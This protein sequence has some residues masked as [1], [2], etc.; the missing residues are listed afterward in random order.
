MRDYALHQ[1]DVRFR[2][3]ASQ[4]RHASQALD[5]DTIHDLRVSI[6]RLNSC[7]RIFAQF[8]PEKAAKKVRRHLH[9]LM[10]AAGEVRDCDI[11]A[12]LFHEAGSAPNAPELAALAELRESRVRNLAD[13]VRE[14]KSGNRLHRSRERLGI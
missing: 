3:M 2:R 6:R 5:A 13:E 4:V 11:A 12:K 1:T 9:A 8:Y 10:Q 7:L 14:W